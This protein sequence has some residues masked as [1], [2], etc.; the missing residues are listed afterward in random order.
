[1]NEGDDRTTL[2]DANLEPDTTDAAFSTDAITPFTT[3]VS[4][5]VISYRKRDVDPDGISVK[6]FLDGL[7]MGTNILADDSSKQVKEITFEVR[8]TK[9]EEKTVIEI[10]D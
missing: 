7:I 2:P 9:G 10:E 3:R 4:I 6:G 1:M 8:K 5:K